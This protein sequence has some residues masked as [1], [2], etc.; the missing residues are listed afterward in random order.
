MDTELATIYT[1]QTSEF[2]DIQS[3]TPHIDL[4]DSPLP[5]SL[6]YTFTNS[7]QLGITSSIADHGYME[8]EFDLAG[9][10][11][12]INFNFGNNLNGAQIRQGI[13]HLI[14]KASFATY[15]PSISGHATPIDNPLPTSN[16][17]LPTPN[18]CAW[19]SNF[20][21]SGSTCSV[22]SPGGTAYRL[23]AAAGANGILWL[24]APGSVDLN[25][26][27]QHFVNAGVATGFNNSTS[28]L[29]GIS[30]AAAT[31]PINFFIRNDDPARLDF[32]NSLAEQICY[33][34]TGSYST[35]CTYL[36]VTRGPA[37][38][39]GFCIDPFPCP[40]TWGMYTAAF[41]NVYPFDSSLYYAYNSRFVSGAPSIQPPNGPCS[42]QSV[43]TQS[44]SNFIYLCSPN[45]DN[46]S[47]QMELSSCLSAAGDPSAGQTANG[48]GANCPNTSQLS[49]ISAGVQAE[50]TFGKGAYT[51]PVYE[52]NTQFG[53]LNNG[54]TGLI[55]D[56]GLGL[57]NP[58]TWLNAWN[59]N[60]VLPGTVRQGFRQTTSSVSPYVAS[61]IWDGYL[62]TGVYDSL[63]V[64]N[65]LSSGQ[66]IYW[67]ALNTQRLPNSALTYTPPLK[68]N[69]T[70]RVTLRSDLF[71]QDG[72]KV[73]S[74]D[75]AFSYLSLKGAGA[76]AGG[77]AAPM[78]GVTI[79]G[80]SQFDINLNAVGPFTLQS[81][82]SLPILPGAYWTNAGSSAWNSAVSTCTVT[83]AACYPAQYTINT[84]TPTQT[85]CALTCVFPTADM[86]VNVAQTGASYDPIANHSLVGSGGWQC[87][88]GAT[89]GYGC[90][91][92]NVQN[93]PVGGSYTLTRFGKGLAPA[94]SISGIYSHSSGNLA[95]YI[96]SQDNGDFTHD[97]LNFAVVASCFGQPVTSSAPCAH[98]Q[99][100][101]G[102][103]GGPIPVGLTQIAIVNR[104]VGLNWVGP[105]NWA[106]AP[107]TG[108]GS[109]PPVLHEGSL[110]LNPSSIAGCSSPYPTGGYDC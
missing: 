21:E 46:I 25:A 63:T 11:W 61:T 10:F 64:P 7:T 94:S 103:N 2:A 87:G 55:N 23:H 41:S 18:P 104:F 42:S 82:T 5:P 97:F 32:G 109:L 102:A 107:P 33:L 24:Q 86:N 95:L 78:T 66:M 30:S 108:I 75:V 20:S 93:P 106:T 59:P 65:P 71:F 105:Y 34:F 19:D 73:T 9:N 74:F 4:T 53:Y 12:G 48:P 79:L 85:V 22:G 8:I 29:T 67:A 51:I 69:S 84:T 72:R 38:A 110:T 45:Y 58:F 77:G 99:Q 17:G 1:D 35:P 43:P 98:Y 90:S 76:I 31:N 50:D 81:L 56:D 36:T 37:S 39:F 15:E 27:A 91:S 96:W 40:R 13:A 26:A 70:Y 47:S 44:P 100:G 92:S 16:G 101:I 80:P 28:V 49:A 83:G 6:I 54:W 89:L 88:T 14:D 60:P 52:L 3:R 57:P 62:V 68:T